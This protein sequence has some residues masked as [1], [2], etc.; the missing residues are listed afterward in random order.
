MISVLFYFNPCIYMFFTHTCLLGG[1]DTTDRL[2]IFMPDALRIALNFNFSAVISDLT[3]FIK[4]MSSRKVILKL[5]SSFKAYNSSDVKIWRMSDLLRV[6]RMVFSSRAVSS[7]LNL[8]PLRI[9][10]RP[11]YCLM[12]MLKISFMNFF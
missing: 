7:Q 9:S 10:L 2:V 8:A 4:S 6:R 5:L 12:L 3:S 1:S 11:K